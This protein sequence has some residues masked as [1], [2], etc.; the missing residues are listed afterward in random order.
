MTGGGKQT[1]T[2][3]S[4]QK[5]ELPAWL[6]QGAERTFGKA[7]AAAEAN[8]ITPYT[9]PVA[10]GTNQQLA[11]AGQAALN[12]SA[13]LQQAR[14]FT[15][16]AGEAGKS[17]VST[18]AWG[19]APMQQYMNPYVQAVQERTM[20]TMRRNNAM[21]IQDVGDSAQASKAF[22]GGRHAIIESETRNNQ[23]R[24]MLDYLANSNASAYDDAYNRFAGDQDRSLRAQSTNAQLSEAALMRK[25]AAAG[26][27]QGLADGDINNLV[28]TGLIDQATEDGQVQGNYNEFLRMQ[29]APM[30]RYMQLMSMLS[31]APSDKTVTTN[32]TT[33]TK[34]SGSLLSALLGGAQIAASVFSDRRLKRDIVKIGEEA[35]GLGIYSYRYLWG[36]TRHTGYMADEVRAVAPEAVTRAFG[37]DMVNYGLLGGA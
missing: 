2:E 34:K 6:N 12:G 16:A 24:N 32:G 23:Q 19:A 10:A 9:G 36:P 13:Q 22:G 17:S 20:G 29:D 33:T 37:F 35:N 21:E 5:I 25:L 11:T 15:Q 4:V 31:G 14:D 28:K 8:P 26:Q 1:T 3:N 30:Q 27:A 7:E 18:G